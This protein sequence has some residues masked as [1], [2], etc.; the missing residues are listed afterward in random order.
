MLS[1]KIR[2]KMTCRGKPVQ[3]LNNIR[4]SCTHNITFNG[5][6]FTKETNWGT[7]RS[8]YSVGPFVLVMSTSGMNMLTAYGARC[9]DLL[10]WS[11]S[12]CQAYWMY[13]IQHDIAHYLM[14]KSYLT[15]TIWE[16]H[17]ASLDL[18]L[19]SVAQ[20][21]LMM[22]SDVRENSIPSISQ[23]DRL[24]DSRH[25]TNMHCSELSPQIGI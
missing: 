10:R 9:S 3:E 21:C 19:K 11:P 12:E 13:T 2:Q 6:K 25:L 4:C 1:I 18:D 5:L 8:Y 7:N 24:S 23:P 14:K 20:A 22:K 16:S 17:H 15:F